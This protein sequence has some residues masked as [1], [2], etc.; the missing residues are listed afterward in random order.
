MLE[1]LHLA[2]QIVGIGDHLDGLS[3]VQGEQADEGLGIHADAVVQ[4][5]QEDLVVSGTGD[6]LKPLEL[7]NGVKLHFNHHDSH[8]LYFAKEYIMGGNP[9][10]SVYYPKFCGGM[11]DV[12]AI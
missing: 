8:L 5:V 4:G 7:G 3:E 2:G 6:L 1:M 10:Q 12:Q 9:T 11:P